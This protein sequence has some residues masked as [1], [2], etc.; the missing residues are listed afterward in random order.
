MAKLGPDLAAALKTVVEMEYDRDEESRNFDEERL[1]HFSSLIAQATGT[2][3][4]TPGVPHAAGGQDAALLA[5]AKAALADLQGIMPEFE[6]SGD[7]LHPGW[8]TIQELEAAIAQST[9]TEQ[10]PPAT[11]RSQYPTE[12]PGV[13]QIPSARSR[14]ASSATTRHPTAATGCPRSVSLR[15]RLACAPFKPF[16]GPNWFEEDL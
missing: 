13:I 15:C 7:R 6:P 14:P 5:A 8:K 2:A 9:A 1:Q 16:A 4:M 10:K 3:T 11:S 12:T